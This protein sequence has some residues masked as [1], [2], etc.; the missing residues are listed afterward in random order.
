[1][2]PLVPNGVVIFSNNKKTQKTEK[3]LQGQFYTLRNRT[4]N[5]VAYILWKL[6]QQAKLRPEVVNGTKTHDTFLQ[7]QRVSLDREVQLG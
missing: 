5:G 7:L 2:P 6:H 3:P 1:M 4:T